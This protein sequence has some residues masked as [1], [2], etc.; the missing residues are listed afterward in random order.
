M[1]ETWYSGILGFN[2]RTASYDAEYKFSEYF[3]YADSELSRSGPKTQ[4]WIEN[5][6]TSEDP[7]ILALAQ[8]MIGSTSEMSQLQRAQYVSNFVQTVIT[9]EYDDV[10]GSTEYYKFPYETLYEGRGDCEDSALLY[11]SLMKAMG[12]DTALL[13]LGYTG[14]GHAVPMVVIEGASGYSFEYDGKTFVCCEVTSDPKFFQMFSKDIGDRPNGW[15]EGAQL[16]FYHF[17]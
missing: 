14:S 6:V 4:E 12:Y 11:I 16:T 8:N 9:Y 3:T 7:A 17:A 2:N 5:F 1:A 13:R 10:K 15:E